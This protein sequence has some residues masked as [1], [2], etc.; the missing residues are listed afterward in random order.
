MK[1][2]ALCRIHARAIINGS[3]TFDEV[4]PKLKEGVKEVLISMGRE[5]LLPREEKEESST[6]T[7]EDTTQEEKK[8]P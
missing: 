7:P 8:E 5:D 2:P 3:I 1:Y 4:N 6:T